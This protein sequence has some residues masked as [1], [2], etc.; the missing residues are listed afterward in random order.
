MSQTA[1][2]HSTVSVG[3]T[4]ATENNKEV[5]GGNLKLTRTQ[6]GDQSYNYDVSLNNT[7]DLSKDGSLTIGN[8]VLNNAGLQIGSGT[9]GI[10]IQTGTVNFGG[11]VIHNVA[12]G[13]ASSDVATVG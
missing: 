3:K 6:N 9:T 11:N 4:T 2:A 10:T 12:P 7:L 5:K 13:S 1:G 8:T